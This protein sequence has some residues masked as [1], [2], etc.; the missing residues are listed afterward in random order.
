M[1]ALCWRYVGSFFALGRFLGAFYASCCAFCRSWLFFFTFWTILGSIFE[2]LGGVGEGFEGSKRIFFDAFLCARAC[3]AKKLRMCK[4]HSFSYG[5]SCFLHIACFLHKPTNDT[6]SLL[7]RVE[8]SFPHILCKKLALGA[9]LEVLGALLGLIW[10]AFGRSWVAPGPSWVV[11]GRLLGT[12][13]A[14]LAVSWLLCGASWL[15]FGCQ[16]LPGPRF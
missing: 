10:P 6:T 15:H 11:L 9:I 2:G 8:Q 4:N 7:E 12:S 14:L 3:N 1:L 16:D 5:F 13:W